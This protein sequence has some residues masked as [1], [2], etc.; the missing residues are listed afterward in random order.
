MTE[1]GSG[2]SCLSSGGAPAP[3]HNVGTTVAS[4]KH[5]QRPVFSF[6]RVLVIW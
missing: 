2:D 6:G 4:D 1:A 3:H 5:I